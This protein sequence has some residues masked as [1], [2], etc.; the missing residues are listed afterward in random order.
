M[1]WSLPI[2][3]KLELCIIVCF[4]LIQQKRSNLLSIGKKVGTSLRGSTVRFWQVFGT[5]VGIPIKKIVQHCCS[6]MQSIDDACAGCPLG[7]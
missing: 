7:A 2:K 5:N 1:N 4:S 6:F 3:N